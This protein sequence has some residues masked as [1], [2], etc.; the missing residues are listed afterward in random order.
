VNAAARIEGLTKELGASPLISETV[1]QALSGEP[2][3]WPWLAAGEQAL[4]G[5]THKLALFKLA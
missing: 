4:K 1:K 2:A 5:K 3:T